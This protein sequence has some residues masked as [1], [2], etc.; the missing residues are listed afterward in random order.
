MGRT[1]LTFTSLLAIAAAAC[2]GL[3]EDPG[4]SSGPGSSSP[5]PSGT[6]GTTSVVN[7]AYPASGIRQLTRSQYDNTINDLLGEVSTSQTLPDDPK[8]NEEFELLSVSVTETHHTALAITR[9]D[10]AARDLAAQVFADSTRRENLV[11]CAPSDAKDPCVGDFVDRFGRRAFRRPLSAD[12]R[13]RYLNLVT[14]GEQEMGSPWDGLE[15]ATA[16]FLSSPFFLYRDETGAP[17]PKDSKRYLLDDYALATRLSFLLWNTTPDEELLSAAEAGELSTAAG[18]EKQADRLLAS[19]RAD[20]ALV[21]FAEEWFGFDE[22]DVVSKDNYVFPNFNSEVASAMRGEARYLL[23]KYLE[24]GQD[25]LQILT[26]QD[27][28]VEEQ[29][30]GVYG[31]EGVTGS[32]PVAI[33]FPSDWA[34]GGL[35]T[36]GAFLAS[37]A[38]A[39]RTSP[40]VRGLFV[41][42]RLLCRHISPPPPGVEVNP[43]VG[44]GNDAVTM[45]E[46]L[47]K[48]HAN[49]ECAGCHDQMDPLG[50]AFEHF[51]G[52][53]QYRADDQGLPLDVTGSLDGDSFDGA[54][55]LAK[56]LQ[57]HPETI[58]C[59]VRQFYRQ[60]L[61]HHESEDEKW[62]IDELTQGFVSD[63]RDF[64]RLVRRIVTSDAFRVSGGNR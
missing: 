1:L 35:L 47:T 43:P 29:L 37:Q 22:L 31:F 55:G 33:T 2:T 7:T 14:L 10:A 52:I 34:R 24:P 4:A 53:G 12:E 9:Y 50:L 18:L 44:T 23:G 58:Q 16:A 64:R 17:D 60:A 26:T 46:W 49:K 30:A 32:T 27:G 45:R 63:K 5:N 42:E 62:L 36:T 54:R 51:D 56:V 57:D 39:T 13:T 6:G 40:T 25:F 41:A 38:R 8:S 48:Q 11:G 15:A 59:V 28:Y 19:P 3:I 61:G 21:D 20:E